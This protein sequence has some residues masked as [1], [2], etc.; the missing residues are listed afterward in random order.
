[1]FHF[2][3]EA[4]RH[5]ARLRVRERLDVV[6]SIA[7]DLDFEETMSRALLLHPHFV[8]AQNDVRVDHFSAGGTNGSRVRKERGIAVPFWRRTG[9]ERVELNHDS[10]SFRKA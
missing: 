8:I 7:R 6:L 3:R 9:E 4:V 10:H 2:S 5:G 1:M